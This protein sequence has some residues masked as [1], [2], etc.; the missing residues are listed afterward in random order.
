[1][2][3]SKAMPNAKTDTNNKGA[4]ATDFIGG[5]Y[6]YPDGDYTVRERIVREHKD[7]QQGLMWFL[8]NDP[9]V[10]KPYT[11]RCSRGACPKTSSPT[12]VDGP[13][14]STSVRPAV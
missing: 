11:T 2:K 6:G 9:R 1:M 7:Y 14:S 12:T 5:N 3:L 4:F 8:V 10:P 13:T